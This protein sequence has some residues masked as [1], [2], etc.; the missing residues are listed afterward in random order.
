[1]E[2]KNNQ[3]F[4]YTYSAKQQEEIKTIRN[5]YVAPQEDKMALLRKLDSQVT[6]TATMKSIVIGIIGALL[7]GVGM[8]CCMVWAGGW[9]FPGIVVGVVGIVFVSLAYPL[10]NRILKQEREKI[11]PEILRL[12]EELLK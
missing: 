9:F 10:Y 7:L 6:K 4:Q 8:S 5:K 2:T 3:S 11:A 1:M 12:T